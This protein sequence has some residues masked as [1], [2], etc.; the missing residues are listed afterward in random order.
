M[1]I[2][3]VLGQSFRKTNRR[4]GEN[5]CTFNFVVPR[6]AVECMYRFDP[7]GGLFVGGILEGAH[8]IMYLFLFLVKQSF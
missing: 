3:K 6:V 4:N 7:K 5:V 8:F 1:M 2:V